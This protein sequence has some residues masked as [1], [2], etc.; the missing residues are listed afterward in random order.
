LADL[1][2]T[3]IFNNS[4]PVVTGGKAYFPRNDFGRVKAENIGL[5]I[6][7]ENINKHARGLVQSDRSFHPRFFD[8]WLNNPH[9][10]SF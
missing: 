9:K 4:E 2:L 8:T 1:S 5:Y 3:L 7:R 6:E 10:S